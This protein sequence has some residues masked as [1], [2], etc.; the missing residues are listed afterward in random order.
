MSCRNTARRGL[1]VIFAAILMTAPAAIAD[2]QESSDEEERRE[3]MRDAAWMP[4]GGFSFGA[5]TQSISGQTASSTATITPG[6]GDSFISEIVGFEGKLYTP[7]RLDDAP[8]KPRIFLSGGAHIP[9]ADGL[10]GERIEA[11]FD[12]APS[13]GPNPN[14]EFQQNCAEFIP[15]LQGNPA[16]GQTCS[17]RVRNR[18]TINALWFAGFGLDLTL[19]V[20]EDQFH[21]LPAVEYYGMSVQSVGEFRRTTAGNPGVND[22]IEIADAVGDA[23]IYHGISPSITF[24]VDVYEDGPVRWSMFMRARYIFYL[25]DPD[26]TS[27]SNLGTNTINFTAGIDDKAPAATAGFQVTWTGK[28]QRGGRR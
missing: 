4:S 22:F 10:I 26:V 7:L 17:L 19:P 8:A 14:P 11:N 28:R 27:S 12:L 3:R 1:G 13:G 15:D 23:E 18:T 5:Y 9:L 24:L 2:D 25:D 21:I 16:P 20:W 6:S